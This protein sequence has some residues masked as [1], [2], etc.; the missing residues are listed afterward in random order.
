[1]ED[2]YDKCIELG[3]LMIGQKIKKVVRVVNQGLTP[4]EVAFNIWDMLPMHVFPQV[5]E[6]HYLEQPLKPL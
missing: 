3:S 4:V 2:P 6:M 1:M 5:P